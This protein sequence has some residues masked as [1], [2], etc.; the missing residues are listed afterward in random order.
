L[1]SGDGKKAN[2]KKKTTV[3]EGE[4]G[5]IFLLF[6]KARGGEKQG[7]PKRVEEEGPKKRREHYRRRK[8]QVFQG[9][10]FGDL[11]ALQNRGQERRRLKNGEKKKG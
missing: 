10:P 1:F 2:I 9:G 6:Q 8:E 3:R 11:F 5:R 7:N 4:L